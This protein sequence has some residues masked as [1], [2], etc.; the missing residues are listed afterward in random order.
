MFKIFLVRHG[1]T[2]GIRAGRMEARLDS[3]LTTFGIR[4]VESLALRLK[5]EQ[6]HGI[7]T[8]PSLRA[9]KTAEIIKGKRELSLIKDEDLYEM[10][11]GPWDGKT[12][13]EIKRDDPGRFKDFSKSPELFRP[14]PEKGESF[15]DVQNR[16][17]SFLTRIKKDHENQTILVVSHTAVLTLMMC[18][19]KRKNIKDFWDPP[20]IQN[21]SLSLVHIQHEEVSIE[22]D[23]DVNHLQSIAII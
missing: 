1:E 18:H 8:S 14:N 12:T 11:I 10:D 3:S 16:V 17:L 9:V 23:A 6:L 20:I 2:E 19:F 13:N 21:A 7:Y 15:K 4:Q 22:L 5:D